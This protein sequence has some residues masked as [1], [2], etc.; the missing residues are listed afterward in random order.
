MASEFSK[1]PAIPKANNVHGVPQPP[2]GTH[3]PV[4]SDAVIKPA[5]S[6]V[7]SDKPADNQPKTK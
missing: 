3:T 5:S 6:H 7:P 4:N 1:P 2:S